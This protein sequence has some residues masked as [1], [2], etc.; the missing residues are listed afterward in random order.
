[1][2]P[3]SALDLQEP[4]LALV[5]IFLKADLYEF[6]GRI[7]FCKMGISGFVW[8]LTW[9]FDKGPSPGNTLFCN[10]GIQHKKLLPSFFPFKT[11]SC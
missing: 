5:S 10:M 7:P 11:S 9:P 6:P 2:A 3:V 4:V 8:G 1:L